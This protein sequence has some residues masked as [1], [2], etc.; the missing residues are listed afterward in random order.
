MARAAA[1]EASQLWEMGGLLTQVRLFL[2]VVEA[3]NA[4]E[5]PVEANTE[6]P[7][8]A[9]SDALID[10]AG[11]HPAPSVD[12]SVAPSPVENPVINAAGHSPVNVAR[13]S[14]RKLQLHF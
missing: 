4:A 5:N 2:Q 8:N 1:A 7:V 3:P 6:A 9:A 11:E 12:K 13:V 14:A 10:A